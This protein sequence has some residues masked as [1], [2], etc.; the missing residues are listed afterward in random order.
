MNQ[1]SKELSLQTK[2]YNYETGSVTAFWV[3]VIAALFCVIFKVWNVLPIVTQILSYIVQ[4]FW[5]TWV[6][7][8]IMEHVT[9][10]RLKKLHKKDETVSGREKFNEK[11]FGHHNQLRSK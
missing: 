7:G 6:F 3:W 5:I 10:R 1:V 11:T 9:K 2:L 8:V 4:V